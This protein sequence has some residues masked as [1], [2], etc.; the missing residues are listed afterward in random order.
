MDKITTDK[1]YKKGLMRIVELMEITP[2]DYL[3]MEN[4]FYQGV[5]IALKK[6]NHET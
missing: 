2:D 3:V 1:E 5:M 6:D 4:A